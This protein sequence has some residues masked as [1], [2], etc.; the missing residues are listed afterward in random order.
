MTFNGLNIIKLIYVSYIYIYIYILG[1]LNIKNLWTTP[2]VKVNL[3]KIFYE[4][5]EGLYQKKNT[6]LI[7]GITREQF[8][9]N[10]IRK[11]LA[12]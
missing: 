5:V 6:S 10:L 11:K 9:F 3:S 8:V 7:L 2:N 12:L 4:L 1:N